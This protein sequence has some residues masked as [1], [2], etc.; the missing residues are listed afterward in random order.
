MKPLNL[1]EPPF[2]YKSF[3]W[4]P[5]GETISFLVSEDSVNDLPYSLYFYL[6]AEKRLIDVS[7]MYDLKEDIT[8]YSWSPDGSSIAISIGNHYSD[9]YV[10]DIEEGIVQ[11]LTDTRFSDYSLTWSPDSSMIAFVGNIGLGTSGPD[12]VFVVDKYGMVEP[13]QITEESD[14]LITWLEWRP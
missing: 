13:I 4:S 1:E 5:D 9:I 8:Q 3:S 10:L 7:K 6:L 11:Q 14:K 12:A 2:D